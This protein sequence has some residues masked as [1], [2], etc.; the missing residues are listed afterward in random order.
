VSDYEEVVNEIRRFRDDRD[1]QQFHRPAEVAA[2][3]AI[4][5]AELQELFLWNSRQDDQVVERRRSQVEEELADVF[6]HV[7]NF[8]LATDID[9]LGAVRRK[10]AT[11][12]EHYPVE[13]AKGVSRKYDE[14]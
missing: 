5:A 1:W 4:E 10:L 7:V 8:A 9:L 2:A 14:L 6:I 13:R 3:I 12:A 11:N